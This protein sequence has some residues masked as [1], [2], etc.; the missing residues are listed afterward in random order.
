MQHYSVHPSSLAFSQSPPQA[1]SHYYSLCSITCMALCC[2]A[3]RRICITSIHPCT[4]YPKFQPQAFVFL[5]SLPEYPH[6]PALPGSLY[7]CPYIPPAVTTIHPSLRIFP[8]PHSPRIS[9]PPSSYPAIII[10]IH[11]LPIHPSI[12][13]PR[14]P[15]LLPT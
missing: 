11:P 7:Y 2:S 14:P 13:P 8:S 6:I 10:I 12:H 3:P 5:S 1:S 9:L 4:S 15:F